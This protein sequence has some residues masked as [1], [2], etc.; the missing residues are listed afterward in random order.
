[1]VTASDVPQDS[2]KIDIKG[3]SRVTALIDA[4]PTTDSATLFKMCWRCILDNSDDFSLTSQNRYGTDWKIVTYTMF[5]PMF[6]KLRPDFQAE[7][8]CRG[9]LPPAYQGAQGCL[10]L[11]FHTGIERAI[12]TQWDRL[13]YAT[14][15]IVAPR[16]PYR[17]GEK[18]SR[19]AS[20]K[21]MFPVSRPLD[22]IRRGILC[23]AEA[24]DKARKG[25]AVV[26]NVDYTLRDADHTLRDPQW[27]RYYIYISRRLLDFVISC[28][29]PAY[30][31]LLSVT[32]D[33]QVLLEVHRV[34]MVAKRPEVLLDGLKKVQTA[35]DY[36]LK[37]YGL[38][39]W[40]LETGGKSHAVR[41]Y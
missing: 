22:V 37:R 33:G 8:L 14:S 24:H 28:G 31:V 2:G 15:I 11:T 13:G 23:L 39:D 20:I 36:D 1:M 29:L 10:L 32:E 34:D 7:I 38:G 18:V 17:D 41:K 6:M 4:N 5:A 19:Q 27:S 9:H 26:I 35:T 25:K 21:R 40:F 16:S 30:W 3:F 12:C